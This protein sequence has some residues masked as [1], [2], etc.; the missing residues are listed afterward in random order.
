MSGTEIFRWLFAGIF[1]ALLVMS[2]YFRRRARRASG[3][4]AR[5]DDGKATF[6]ARMIG[7]AVL[8]LPMLAY[9]A[10]PEWMAWS[11]FDAPLWIRWIGV[12]VGLAMLPALYWVLTSIGSNI[13]ETTLTKRDHVLVTHG[14]YRWVRHPLY[15]VAMTAFVA[16]GIVA[17]NWFIAIAAVAATALIALVVIPKEEA[18][19][20]RKF[21]DEY[22]RYI[23]R[24][25]ALT[26][27]LKG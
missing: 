24:T 25:G 3:A 1:I 9:I 10:N 19:L 8:Y 23:G 2:G 14:P 7:A 13:S 6:A 22:R 26:P 16:L 27:R 20:V 11:S 18:Q 5:T 21:G 12:A 15:A 17:A 4:I